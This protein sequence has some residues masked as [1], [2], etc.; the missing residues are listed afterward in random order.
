MSEYIAPEIFYEI[1]TLA[2]VPIIGIVT[3][4]VI[5]FLKS[6]VDELEVRI[7]NE[8]L[9]RYTAMAEDAIETAVV[10]VN[11]TFVETIKKQGS[12]DD[13]AME[14]SF[15]IAK[16]KALVIMGEFL[17]KILEAAYGDIDAW[18][19]NK[20]EYYVNQNKKQSNNSQPLL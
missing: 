10:S 8:T 14:E 17:K 3:K 7:Q 12:F 18:I 9:N 16:N 2:I 11:Q 20:I 6:K 13:A 4:F 1:I 19:D 5:K 15:K